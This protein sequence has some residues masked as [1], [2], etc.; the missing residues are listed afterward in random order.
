MRLHSNVDIK[1]PKE[2][3]VERDRSATEA[4]TS[5]SQ[6]HK[7]QRVILRSDKRTKPLS[8][9]GWMTLKSAV[10]GGDHNSVSATS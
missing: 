10:G 3:G 8:S 5:E 2:K 6:Q 4:Q 7:P 9:G 1:S